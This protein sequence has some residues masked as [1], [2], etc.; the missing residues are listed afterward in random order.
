MLPAIGVR[1]HPVLV[2]S[3]IIIST[4]SMDIMG[5]SSVVIL[6]VVG[7]SG[8]PRVGV[9]GDTRPSRYIGRAGRELG[10]VETNTKIFIHFAVLK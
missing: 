10:P 4:A 8:N 3:V 5:T 1:S 7:T 6:V 9:I 2:L